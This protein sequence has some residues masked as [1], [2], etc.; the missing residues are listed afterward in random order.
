VEKE[1][2]RV[3]YL[4]YNM[5]SDHMKA[6]N[7]RAREKHLHGFLI[8]PSQEHSNIPTMVLAEGGV[9]AINNF[10]RMVKRLIIAPDEPGKV[11]IIHKLIW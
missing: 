8:K 4:I 7:R 5:W 9:N 10:T 1:C 3:V 2:R 6:I 11:K